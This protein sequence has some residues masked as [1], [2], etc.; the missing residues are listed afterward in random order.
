MTKAILQDMMNVT[1]I[2]EVAS[3]SERVRG[4]TPAFKFGST[5][6]LVVMLACAVLW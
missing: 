5:G 1:I 2:E 3:G 6:A 4:E